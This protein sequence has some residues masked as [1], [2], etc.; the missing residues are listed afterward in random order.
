MVGYVVAVL[1]PLVPQSWGMKKKE[2]LR[3]TLRLPAAFLC[4]VNRC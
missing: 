3:D 4:T 1:N 2:S